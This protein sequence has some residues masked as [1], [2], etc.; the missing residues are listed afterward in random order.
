MA[1][2]YRK[3]LNNQQ[4]SERSNLENFSTE[5]LC[6]FLNRLLPKEFDSFLETVIFESSNDCEE[7]KKNEFSNLIWK[8]QYTIEC[9]QQGAKK[10]PDLIC[11]S[12]GKPIILF[13]I[14]INADFTYRLDGSDENNPEEYVHQLKDYGQWL[15]RKNE[16]GALVLLSFRTALPQNFLDSKDSNEYGISN[17]R[18]ISWNDIYK[19]LKTGKVDSNR[20]CLVED[21]KNYLLE[22]GMAMESPKREDFAIFEMFLSGSGKR[23]SEMMKYVT[24][25]LRKKYND[26]LDWGREESCYNGYL[27]QTRHIE[28]QVW[29]WCFIKSFAYTYIAW[30]VYFPDEQD[31][32]GWKRNLSN[33]PEE[34]FVFVGLFS[35]HKKDDLSGVLNKQRD[36]KWHWRDS[37]DDKSCELVGMKI[38]TLHSFYAHKE[39]LTEEVYKFIEA[40]F[41]EIVEM[42]LENKCL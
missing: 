26:R 41:K 29:S 10:R 30:G 6:D 2:L 33:L 15:K 8:T 24:E 27:Y 36:E 12:G 22:A 14:K 5:V 37:L 11:F 34:P 32:L 17:R 38:C 3:L 18:H 4:T 31:S 19:W 16:N 28:K 9:G 20:I 40:G 1:S 13:E 25:E 39:A 42:D 7:F 23:I 35:D 21:F